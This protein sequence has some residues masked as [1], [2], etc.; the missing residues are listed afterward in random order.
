MTKAAFVLPECTICCLIRLY[1]SGAAGPLNTITHLLT[2]RA[3]AH[4]T[5]LFFDYNTDSGKTQRSKK[6]ACAGHLGA[7]YS[8]VRTTPVP[9][10]ATRSTRF[11]RESQLLIIEDD[12]YSVEEIHHVHGVS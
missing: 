10:R 8:P 5:H 6:R 3:P 11:T 12:T 9:S 1:P 7:V 2:L 4:R